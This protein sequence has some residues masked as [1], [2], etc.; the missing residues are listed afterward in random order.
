MKT[1]IIFAAAIFAVAACGSQ[2]SQSSTESE[3]EGIFTSIA[4]EIEK[5]SRCRQIANHIADRITEDNQNRSDS[6]F[7]AGTRTEHM[8]KT[9]YPVLCSTIITAQTLLPDQ[10]YKTERSMF[11]YDRN[12]WAWLPAET[13]DYSTEQKLETCQQTLRNTDR[14]Y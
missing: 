5:Q 12:R 14:R 3:C 6:V 11:C 1:A 2:A 8:P 9:E 4:C 13:D 7:A 10:N